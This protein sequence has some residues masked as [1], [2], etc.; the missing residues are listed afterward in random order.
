MN[1]IRRLVIL[2]IAVP[3]SMAAGD[4]KPDPAKI[5]D[6]VTIEVGKKLIVKFEKKGD[7]LSD[8]KVVKEATEKPPTPTFDFS[9]MDDNLMLTTNNPFSKDLKFAPWLA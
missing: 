8:P 9:K 2:L 1:T 5:K 4:D 7:A 6:K 3:T